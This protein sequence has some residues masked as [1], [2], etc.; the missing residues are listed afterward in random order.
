MSILLRTLSTLFTTIPAFIWLV[1]IFLADDDDYFW[2]VYR[3]VGV[4]FLLA[5]VLLGGIV[6]GLFFRAW[7]RRPGA[8]IAGQCTL[9]WLAG[10]VTL[11]LLNLT[12]LCIGH[13]NGDGINDL[14]LCMVQTALVGFVYSFPQVFLVA[15]SAVPGGLIIRRFFG[16]KGSLGE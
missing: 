12:P 1:L 4:I 14:T 7:R 16:H 11:V 15:L 9:A 5:S 2:I 8:W 10:L 3:M 6:P 13:D